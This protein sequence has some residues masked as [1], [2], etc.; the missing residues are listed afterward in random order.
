MDAFVE[1]LHPVIAGTDLWQVEPLTILLVWTWH[2]VYRIVVVGGTDVLVQ[3]G[4]F[5]PN[6]TPAHVESA[7]PER[8]VRKAGWIGVGDLMALRIDGQLIVTSPVV[9]I[10]TERSVASVVH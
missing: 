10:A 7:S 5:F 6:P 8:H 4:S 9:A 1:P 3:G 2:S